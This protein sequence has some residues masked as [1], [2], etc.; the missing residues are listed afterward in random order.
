MRQAA[1][2]DD[3]LDVD[4]KSHVGQRQSEGADGSGPHLGR[5]RVGADAG[6]DGLGSN[7]LTRRLLVAPRDALRGGIDLQA[8]AR[9]AAA[10]LP[11]GED[12]RV[13]DFAGAERR[14]A[15]Q[16]VPEH[17]GHGDAGADGHHE[18]GGGPAARA[19]EALGK[20][21]GAPVV[22]ERGG[23]TR[24]LLNRAGQLYAA[25]FEVRRVH[26]GPLLL[27]DEA[28]ADQAETDQSRK[29][30]REA[31][32]DSSHLRGH[33]LA[34][35]R[36]IALGEDRACLVDDHP[37]NGGTADVDTRKYRA[38]GILD[39]THGTTTCACR[40]GSAISGSKGNIGRSI[41]W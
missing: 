23:Y 36:L 31:R 7:V 11:A 17:E 21:G 10:G 34:V 19:E 20:A 3:A 35:G 25:Q 26:D 38:R 39:G 18:E 8:A 30:A 29:V 22:H 15:P 27:I 5:D 24:G 6:L 13:P 28:G 14:A 32:T 33:G 12:G 1:T 2:D 37:L 9:P 4:G 16:V 41:L 40:S